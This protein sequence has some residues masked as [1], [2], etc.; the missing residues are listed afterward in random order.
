MGKLLDLFFRHVRGLADVRHCGIE[1]NGGLS[2]VCADS[3][4]RDGDALREHLSDFLGLNAIHGAAT[5]LD[6][7]EPYEVAVRVAARTKTREEALKVGREVDGMAV[8]GVGH[9][10]KRVPHQDRR[11]LVADRAALNVLHAELDMIRTERADARKADEFQA[12][13]S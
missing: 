6:A 7:P 3:D 8:S 4:Q 9:T 2:S 12:R 11:V 10:G 1:L 13:E 5:P